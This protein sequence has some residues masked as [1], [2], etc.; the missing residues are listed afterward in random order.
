MNQK[1]L[2]PIKE[3]KIQR[4]ESKF[5]EMEIATKSLPAMS[6]A[7]EN[8]QDSLALMQ[9][10]NNLPTQNMDTKPKKDVLDTS[11]KKALIR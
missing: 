7:L 10:T 3:D 9:T 4:L 6:S 2:D 11:E 5:Q 1:I 8:I